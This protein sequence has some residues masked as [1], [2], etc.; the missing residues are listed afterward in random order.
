MNQKIFVVLISLAIIALCC[1]PMQCKPLDINSKEDI[2]SDDG[3]HGNLDK[4]TIEQL[5]QCDMDLETMELC[6]RCAK[7]T[8]S[9]IVYPLCCANEDKIK[10]WCHDYVFFGAL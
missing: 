5:R 6:M 7:I 3:Y 10:D 2:Y 1:R 4:K 8:K 9:T